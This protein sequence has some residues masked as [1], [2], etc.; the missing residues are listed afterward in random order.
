MEASHQ[1]ALRNPREVLWRTHEGDRRPDANT[2]PPSQATAAHRT[3]IFNVKYSPNLGDGIIAEC[4]EGELRRAD[5]C[6]DPVSLDLAGRTRFSPAHGRHRTAL[7]SLLEWLPPALRARAIPAF[8]VPLVRFRLA[9]RWYRC[10]RD[11]DSVIVGGGALFQDV[12]QNFPIKIAQALRLANRRR[13]PVAIASVG[14][15]R[16]WTPAGRKRLA[17]GLLAARLVSLS[18]RDSDSG[19]AWR[20][21]LGPLG[22]GPARFA[23]D[24]GLLSARQY[25]SGP[26]PAPG[27]PHMALCVTAPIA[28]R[29]HHEE[30]HVESHLEAWM[31]AVARQLASRGHDVTLFTN[32]SPEDRL[33]RDRL[34]A[35]LG[36][37]PCVHFAPDFARPGDLARFLS[38]FGCVLAH[39][40]HAC[41]VAY[42]YGVPTVGFAWDRKLESF[43]EQTGRSRFVVDPRETSPMDLADLAVAAMA[44]GIDAEVHAQL[45]E[46][47]TSAIRTLA[48]ELT[49][50]TAT[51]V[52]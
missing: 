39:R 37:E 24:P 7:L 6:L 17:S 2:S 19:S 20:S 52:P 35:R 51:G 5:P 22:V 28:L 33:F 46:A 29:L 21:V 15:S 9:P 8:L 44:E 10:L 47:A 13:L 3:A 45:I 31:R 36:E 43:F 40:L 27:H 1:L 4:L 18:V 30:G 34:R 26:A 42:S 38:G 23:P 11:C 14:V 25:G 16:H 48:G 49:A 50:R 41:I 12:D 32:G